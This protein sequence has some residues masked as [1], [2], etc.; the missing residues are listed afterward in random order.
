MT[1]LA[2]SSKHVCHVVDPQEQHDLN[3]DRPHSSNSKYVDEMCGGSSIMDQ[4]PIVDVKHG[5]I[6]AGNDERNRNPHIRKLELIDL[7]PREQR[8]CRTGI[9]NMNQDCECIINN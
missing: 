5:G 4:M 7:Y 9:Y 6:A 1:R 3:G 2:H 8:G